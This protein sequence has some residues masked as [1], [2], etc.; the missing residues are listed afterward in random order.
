MRLLSILAV[1]IGL[2]LAVSS[3]AFADCA[4]HGVTASTA[5]PETVAEMPAQSMPDSTKKT[6]TTTP[7]GG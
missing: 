7:T 2:T 4:G 3:P 1:L 6:T 5:A